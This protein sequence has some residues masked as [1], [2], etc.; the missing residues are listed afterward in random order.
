MRLFS[1]RL[2]FSCQPRALLRSIAGVVKDTS[3]AMMP[4]VAVE[5]SSWVDRENAPQ[6]P[7]A[8]ANAGSSTCRRACA[9]DVHVDRVRT[10][11]RQ[12]IQLQGSFAAQVNADLQIGAIEETLTVTGASPTVDVINNQSTVV[13]DRDVL[14]AIPTTVRNLPMRAAL[15]PGS[16]VTFITLGQYAMTIHGSSFEDTRSPSTA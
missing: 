16:S 10:V 7:T 6:R 12:D 15:I 8:A 2:Y 14:D 4:G 11:V 5:A 9:G 3:G 1:S 13:L